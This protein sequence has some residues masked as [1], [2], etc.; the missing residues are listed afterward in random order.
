MAPPPLLEADSLVYVPSLNATVTELRF[1]EKEFGHDLPSNARVYKQTFSHLTTRAVGWEV[2]LVYPPKPERIEYEIEYVFY[3][4]NGTTLRRSTNAR[5]EAGWTNSSKTWARG[6]RQPLQWVTG[7]YKVELFI[8]G[9]LVAS[10]EFEIVDSRVP[11]EGPFVDLREGLPWNSWQPSVDGEKALLALAGLMEIDPP[12]ASAAASFPWIQ[13]SPMD[14]GL[15]SLQALESLA[16]EDVDLA[17][18]VVGFSWLADDVTMDEWLALRTLTLLAVQDTAVAKF[19]ADFDWLNDGITESERKA[20]DALRSITV[21]HP[22]LAETLLSLPWLS[23]Q[24]T[25]H[26]GAM[27][28]EF[29]RLTRRDP[30]IAQQV[31]HMRLMDG[32]I[33]HWLR[34]AVWTLSKL[35][36]IDPDSL[37]TLRNQPW[38]NNGL[39]EEEARLVD[40]LGS[41]ALKSETGALSIIRMPFLKTFEPAD[42]LAIRSLNELVNFDHREGSERVSNHFQRVMAHPAI[43]DGI[44]NEE[45]KI[46]ATLR[47]VSQHNPDLVDTLLDPAQVTLEERIID[48]PL[49]GEVHIT[50]MRTRPGAERT[51]DLLDRAVRDVEGLM[52]LQ[53]PERQVIYLFEDAIRDSVLGTNFGTH[54]ASRPKVDE[55][56]YAVESALSHLIHETSHYYWHDMPAWLAEGAATFIEPFASKAVTGLPVAVDKSPCAYAGNI[57]E[58]KSLEPKRGSPEFSCNYALGEWLFHDLYRSLDETTFKQGFR[59]LYLLSLTDDLED[60]CEGVKLDICHVEA[61]FKNDSTAEAAAIVDKVIARWYHG[62]KPYDTSHQDTSPADPNL[63][64]DVQAEVTRAYIVLDKDRREET[65][66]DSFSA[67][68]VQGPIYLYLHFSYSRIQDE[69]TLPLTVVEYFED[70]FAYDPHNRK[71]TFKTGWTGS[72]SSYRIGPVEERRWVPGRYWVY[73]YHDGQKIAEVE[74]LVAP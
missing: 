19:I 49:A 57:A 58:L 2:H 17:R 18:R 65:K 54:I 24:L 62:T 55:D 60:T 51:M 6:F 45:A 41:I 50:I 22:S 27:V 36:D 32:P 63:Q 44:T 38:F 72:R 52:G 13:K 64:G 43:S 15:R 42:A 28:R 74:Y 1:Y 30:Q 40:D 9:H 3:R 69:R 61:A 31:G 5:I 8:E 53:F 4:P 23:D 48:L 39:D 59:N 35:H 67:S 46:V 10:G 70:G 68:E 26:E 47:R 11:R 25:D 20:L 12:L 71:A 33:Q 7:L 34:E 29:R 14:E 21:E 37:S 73:V 56:S 66:T 16:K